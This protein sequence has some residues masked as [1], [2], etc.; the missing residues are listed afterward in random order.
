[1][2][3]IA[4]EEASRSM[5]GQRLADKGQ[6]SAMKPDAHMAKQHSARIVVG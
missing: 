6:M 2:Q 1:M 5:C 4:I 3:D